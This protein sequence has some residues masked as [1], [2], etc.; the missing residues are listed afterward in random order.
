MRKSLT[1]ILAAVLVSAM[2]FTGCSGPKTEPTQGTNTTTPGKPTKISLWTFQDI[3]K[4]YYQDMAKLWN[5]ANP[6]EQ[7]ELSVESYPNA[8]MHNKL[9]IALQSGAGA[10]DIADVNINYFTNFLKGDIPLVALNDIVEPVLDKTVKSRFDIYAKDGKY[11]GVDFHVGATVV[12]YN[13]PLMDKAGV[14]VDKIVT[15]DDYAEAGKK[16]LAATGVPMTAFEVNDQRP[17]WPMIVQQGSDYLDKDG[18]VILDN[19]TN[20]KTLESM[21][22]MM[23]DKVAIAIPGGTTSTEEFY[24]FMNKGGIASLTMPMWYMSRFINFMPDLKGKIIIRPMPVW[25]QGDDRSA[26]IGG[27]ATAITKQSKNIDMA[28]KFLAY[29]KLTKEAGIKIWQDLKFDPIRWDVWDAP[30][31]QQPD[32]F[33]GNEKPFSVLLKIKDEINS[34]N[35]KALSSP[36]QDLVKSNVMFKA[37][38]ERSLT[39]EAALKA[40]AEELRKQQK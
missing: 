6:N 15:W 38:K 22:K 39:P 24:T 25:K 30:E 5:T 3:H 19:A 2:T 7:I 20:I 23:D 28:K 37:L 9:L 33:F 11:Y 35:N 40:A 17:F 13:K 8:D 12:Y 36:A 14:D 29:S 10:P 31:L 32:P 1:R 4:K 18:K 27:T 34:V 26:G 21:K 16:V